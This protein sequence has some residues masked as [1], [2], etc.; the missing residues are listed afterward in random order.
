M[1]ARV[2]ADDPLFDTPE[3]AEYLDTEPTTLE[4]WRCTKRYGIEFIKI[5]RRVRYRKSALDAWLESRTVRPQQ[6]E[7]V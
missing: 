3:A 1:P 7:A 6:E 2:T 4:N 5:G